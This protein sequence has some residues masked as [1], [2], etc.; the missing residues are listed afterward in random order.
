[1]KKIEEFSS[2][3][4]SS[5][6]CYAALLWPLSVFQRYS[7]YLLLLAFIVLGPEYMFPSIMFIRELNDNK[8]NFDPFELSVL[9]W[10]I[11]ASWLH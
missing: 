1:M 9:K 8:Q 4:L 5:T 7:C 10:N 3:D 6:L 11:L 2:D